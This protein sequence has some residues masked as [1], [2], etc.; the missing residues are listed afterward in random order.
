MST[1]TKKKVELITKVTQESFKKLGEIA[2][3]LRN[4]AKRNSFDSLAWLDEKMC[5]AT[6]HYVNVVTNYQRVKVARS[7]N[8]VA[9]Y[10]EVRDNWTDGKF[11]SAGGD[12]MAR[13]A[14]ADFAEAEHVLLGYLD[15]SNQ[16]ILTLKKSIEIAILNKQLESKH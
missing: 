16:V 8:E 10:L 3:E 11:V 12:R 14:V 5:E 2:E 9:A 1:T 13:N 6:G 15:A 4:Y 7:N